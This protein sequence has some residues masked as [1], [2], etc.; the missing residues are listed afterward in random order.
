[1]SACRPL[2]VREL[3]SVR[4]TGGGPEKTI[5]RGATMTDRA[6]A[7]VT[8]CYVRDRRDEAFGVT[9]RPEFTGVDYVEVHERHSFD[10]SVWPQLRR[11]VHERAIDIVHAHDYKTNLL[12]LLLG[13]RTRVIPLSTVH[14]WT[15]HSVRERWCYYPADKRVLARFPRLIA[16]S[17]DIARELIEH[18]ARPSRVS[19]ILNGIDHRQFRRDPSRV[20]GA[21]RARGR[22]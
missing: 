20:A 4:G 5:L 2:R 13:R 8:V 9:T 16:V 19:T 15:G 22:K 14:G 21:R 12:A 6:R 11:V 17:S 3:R 7:Q 10:P 1:M 18:G